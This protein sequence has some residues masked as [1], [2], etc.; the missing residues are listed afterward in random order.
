MCRVTVGETAADEALQRLQQELEQ[1]QLQQAGPCAIPDFS[2]GIPGCKG[3]GPR[4]F[5][6]HV[7]KEATEDL[8]RAHFSRWGTVTDVYFP[9]HKKTLKRRPF[10]FVTFSSVEAAEHALAE[11]PLNI[12]GIPIKNLTMV[13]DRDAYYRTKHAT[14]RAALLQALQ[15]IGSSPNGQLGP[16]QLNN[17]AALL[18]MEGVTAE[19]IMGLLPQETGLA[20]FGAGGLQMDALLGGSSLNGFP[21]GGMNMS[22]FGTGAPATAGLYD[23][24]G[25]AGA[26]AQLMQRQVAPPAPAAFAQ[27][28]RFGAAGFGGP[29][30]LPLDAQLQ[31]LSAVQ[32]AALLGQR[33]QLQQVMG[34]APAP[35]VSAAMFQQFAAGMGGLPQQQQFVAPPQGPQFTAQSFLATGGM[36]N[37]GGSVSPA[38]AVNWGGLA[39]QQPLRT[40]GAPNSLLPQG[41]QLAG[42]SST[43]TASRSSSAGSPADIPV[44]QIS[45][46]EALAA[47]SKLKAAQ[48][49]PLAEVVGRHPSPPSAEI[50]SGLGS[51]STN[52]PT[53]TGSPHLG[54][55]P[56]SEGALMTS[57]V[58]SLEAPA[59]GLWGLETRLCSN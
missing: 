3:S 21:A 17:L 28:G 8:V 18:A 6:G 36:A 35:A 54:S 42:T 59:A 4:L 11:S 10:C 51:F 50:L 32:Q 30:P 47:L 7:P 19:A 12:C 20:A 52:S 58:A 39:G 46:D 38:P 44:P 55:S 27:G 5:C 1:L 40:P 13:E 57:R 2:R 22:G 48:Q 26:A 9:R 31:Q 24:F 49:G 23:S 37:V 34:Q 25:I 15:S 56:P 16:D 53:L 14:T 33:M 43:A 45:L 41:I 29:A